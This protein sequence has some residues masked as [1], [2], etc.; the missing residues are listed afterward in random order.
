MERSYNGWPASS[1]PAEVDASR[2][3]VAGVEF[4][5][6]VRAG[7]VAVVLHHVAKQFHHRV[8]PLKNPGCW[9]YA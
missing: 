3:V 1:D 9:G 5:G 8:G 2:F 6:G 7:D 4:V